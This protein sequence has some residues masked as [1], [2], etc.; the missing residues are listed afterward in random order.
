[1]MPYR[2]GDLNGKGHAG[3]GFP[4]RWDRR[5]HLCQLADQVLPYEPHYGGELHI[6]VLNS[7]NRRTAGGPRTPSGDDHFMDYIHPFLTL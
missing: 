6:S 3:L 5:L 7:R 4:L 1:M 2:H